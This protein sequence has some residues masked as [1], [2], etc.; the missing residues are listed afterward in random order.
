[1]KK[2]YIKQIYIYLLS[3]FCSVQKQLESCLEVEA[4]QNFY[5]FTLDLYTYVGLPPVLGSGIRSTPALD[6]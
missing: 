3:T 2:I 1:M 5:T 6:V 4:N